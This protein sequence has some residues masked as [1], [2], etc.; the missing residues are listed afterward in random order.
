MGLGDNQVV[1]ACQGNGLPLPVLDDKST[2]SGSTSHCVRSS[3]DSIGHNIFEHKKFTFSELEP[4]NSDEP[5]QY[6]D[7]NTNINTNTNVSERNS[8][9]TPSSKD[10][11]TA[12]WSD[13]TTTTTASAAV[14][15]TSAKAALDETHDQVGTSDYSLPIIS[16]YI[17][18]GQQQQQQQ[19]QQQKQQFNRMHLLA[20]LNSRSHSTLNAWST[21]SPHYDTRQSFFANTFIFFFFPPSVNLI[22]QIHTK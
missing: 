4:Q 8:T 17:Y 2:P 15:T 10:K 16:E 21:E 12:H 5:F 22:K 11:A 3:T 18:D 7:D 14:T 19:Q 20:T 6:I 9:G 13:N 1:F